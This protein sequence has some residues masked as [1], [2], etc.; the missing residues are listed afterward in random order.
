MEFHLCAFYLL[1][2]IF[3][4]VFLFWIPFYSEEIWAQQVQ[5]EIARE[6]SGGRLGIQPWVCLTSKIL[7]LL[8]CSAGFLAR[9]NYLQILK[10]AVSYCMLSFILNSRI[11]KTSPSGQKAE[12]GCLGRGK[13]GNWLQRDTKDIFGTM[14][15]FYILI[16]AL[17]IFVKTHWTVHFNSVHFIY[18]NYASIK[19]IVCKRNWIQ[20]WVL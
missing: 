2:K 3:T 17:I 5:L 1:A 10:T 18:A 15:R 8:L 19:L 9:K 7:L 13:W 20:C 12:R 16:P 6:L 14:E 11:G 4:G